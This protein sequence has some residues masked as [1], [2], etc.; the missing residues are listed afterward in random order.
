M[1]FLLIFEFIGGLLIRGVGWIFKGLA[2]L[3]D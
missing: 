1:D 2:K 3:L